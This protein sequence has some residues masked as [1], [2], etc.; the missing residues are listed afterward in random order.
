MAATP[1]DHFVPFKATVIRL[2]IGTRCVPAQDSSSLIDFADRD[3]SVRLCHVSVIQLMPAPLSKLRLLASL[4]RLLPCR[5]WTANGK[6]QQQQT[7]QGQQGRFRPVAQTPPPAS[8]QRANP[9]RC[10]RR[11]SQKA[12]KSSPSA[13]ADA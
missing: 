6:R 5:E 9:P 11:P 2:T 3:V 10:D 4:L 12:R 13:P 8:R 1:F 7:Y